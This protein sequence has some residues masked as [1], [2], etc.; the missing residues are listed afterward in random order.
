[1][2]FAST[3]ARFVS[4]RSLNDRH[5]RFVSLRSLNDRDQVQALPVV[6]RAAQRRDETHPAR[7]HGAAA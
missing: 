2:T 1:M 3:P 7:R 4:L 5:Q 6:E